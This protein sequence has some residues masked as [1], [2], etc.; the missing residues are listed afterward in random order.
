[1]LCIFSLDQMLHIKQITRK[2]K[3]RKLQ[4]VQMSTVSE[5]KDVNKCDEWKKCKSLIFKIN[6]TKL[7]LAFNQ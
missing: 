3:K 1:M 7:E 5:G 6:D 2:K 4:R